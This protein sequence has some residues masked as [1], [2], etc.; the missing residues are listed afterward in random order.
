MP[1]VFVSFFAALLL[2]GGVVRERT[3]KSMDVMALLSSSSH[4]HC[5]NKKVEEGSSI[6]CEGYR[7]AALADPVTNAAGIPM[8]LDRTSVP[9][10]P[11]HE[12]VA[13]L[14]DGAQ[15]RLRRAAA[16]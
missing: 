4:T 5:E 3:D 14:F 2:R 10:L 1:P 15:G 16:D 13:Q 7:P 12:L 11:L 6:A 8:S 9:Y